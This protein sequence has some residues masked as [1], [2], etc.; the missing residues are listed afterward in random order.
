MVTLIFLVT[1][2][3]FLLVMVEFSNLA[4][5][6]LPLVPENIESEYGDYQ[7]GLYSKSADPKQQFTLLYKNNSN[8]YVFSTDYLSIH[9][10]PLLGSIFSKY[11]IVNSKNAIP[12]WHPLHKKIEEFRKL[13]KNHE[14]IN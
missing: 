12:R 2:I 7:F 10:I 11:Y 8:K 9:R 3:G 5:F 1:V 14:N 13:Q 6:G 4:V